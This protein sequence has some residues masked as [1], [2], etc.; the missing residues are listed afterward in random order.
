MEKQVDGKTRG[1]KGRWFAECIAYTNI[2]KYMSIRMNTIGKKYGIRK[3]IG[4]TGGFKLNQKS[5]INANINI[6]YSFSE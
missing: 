3:K 6:S 1:T 2:Y 5:R 4:Q